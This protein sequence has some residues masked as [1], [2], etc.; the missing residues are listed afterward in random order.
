[1]TGWEYFA[2]NTGG[3]QFVQ[4][5]DS[6]GAN[7]AEG[8][9][10]GTHKDNMRFVRIARGSLNES[11]CW[12]RR[13]CQRNPIEGKKLNEFDVNFEKLGF[14]LNAYLKSIKNKHKENV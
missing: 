12:L 2:K 13:A 8:A 11:K 14:L 7:I 6:V 4:A 5:A 3:K 1:V 9:G 10:R